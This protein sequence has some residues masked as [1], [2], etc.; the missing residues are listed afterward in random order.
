MLLRTLH[1]LNFFLRFNFILRFVLTS[2]RFHLVVGLRFFKEDG[3]PPLVRTETRTYESR[4]L[5][6]EAE[7]ESDALPLSHGMLTVFYD[8]S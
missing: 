6:C 3:Q 1:V 8:Y 4:V 7:R 5:S 2:L